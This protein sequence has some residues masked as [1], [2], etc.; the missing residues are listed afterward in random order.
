MGDFS[1]AYDM[2][3][4]KSRRWRRSRARPPTPNGRRRW[5]RRSRRG[6][7]GS[8]APAN[9]ASRIKL[10]AYALGQAGVP[11]VFSPKSVLVVSANVWS[12]KGK[13]NPEPEGLTVLEGV[14]GQDAGRLGPDPD[15]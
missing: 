9:T 6:S 2:V 4:V 12:A 11:L 1:M 8:T 7:R 13:L 10:E 15:P 5:N 3:V 14:I